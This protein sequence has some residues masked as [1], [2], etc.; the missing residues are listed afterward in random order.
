MK[1]LL[2]SICPAVIIAI[3]VNSIQAAGYPIGPGNW[4]ILNNKDS[5][6]E[7]CDDVWH[8]GYGDASIALNAV[9]K[10]LLDARSDKDTPAYIKTD[11]NRILLRRKLFR[12]QFAGIVAGGRKKIFCNFFD[13]RMNARGWKSEEISTA[14]TVFYSWS[15]E[16][17][18]AL[19][20]CGNFRGKTGGM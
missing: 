20:T 19:K 5:I 4:A 8:I 14:D 3:A 12:V 6:Y 2:L 1:P 7:P 9:F 10:Y 17:D 18:P 15:I 11:I 13:S 16:Y